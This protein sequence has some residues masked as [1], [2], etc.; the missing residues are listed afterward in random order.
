[1]TGR[2]EQK[3]RGTGRKS[4]RK[5]EEPKNSHK[6]KNHKK[7][8]ERKNHRKE[9]SQKGRGTKGKSHR[10]EMNYIASHHIGPHHM[11]SLFIPSHPITTHPIPSNPV[12]LLTVLVV[13][14]DGFGIST[15]G[16]ELLILR[17]W[18]Q[19]LMCLHKAK[20]KQFPNLGRTFGRQN[21]NVQ[22]SFAGFLLSFA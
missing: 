10:K 8:I 13:K 7:V 18:H 11:T 20:A 12:F 22:I 9:Q 15:T 14:T 4:Q 6:K 1:M 19:H 5:E 2:G 17:V 16:C 21:A 3:G